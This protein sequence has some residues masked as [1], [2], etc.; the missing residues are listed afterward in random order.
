MFFFIF[1]VSKQRGL[2][3]V[4]F[5]SRPCFSLNASFTQLYS[6][7][8]YPPKL[9]GTWTKQGQKVNPHRC[10]PPPKKQATPAHW[11]APHW[12]AQ[13]LLFAY[14]LALLF[15]CDVFQKN[16]KSNLCHWNKIPIQNCSWVNACRGRRQVTNANNFWFWAAFGDVICGRFW[17]HVGVIRGGCFLS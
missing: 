16:Q 11:D 9:Q 1:L 13:S 2:S 10:A 5:W 15:N 6:P 17:W 7:H 14:L 4:F 8:V 3:F 12:C